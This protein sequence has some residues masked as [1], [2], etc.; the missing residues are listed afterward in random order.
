M[1]PETHFAQFYLKITFYSIFSTGAKQLYDTG[2]EAVIKI[3]KKIKIGVPEEKYI[4]S[5]ITSKA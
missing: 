4:F 2:D 1:A 5:P 3:H